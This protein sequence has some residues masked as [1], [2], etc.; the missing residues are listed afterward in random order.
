MF[1]AHCAICHG[2][3]AL[4]V[5]PGFPSLVGVAQR[6]SEGQL[7]SLIRTGRGRMPAFTKLSA[8]D[9]EE[10]TQY[11]GAGGGTGCEEGVGVRRGDAGAVPVYG[12][13]AVQGSGGVSGDGDAVGH[14]CMRSI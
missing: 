12:V 13:S 2:E 4:G 5:Q 8:T 3:K 1:Q 10:L 6:Q 14:C 7:A 9:I 11:L